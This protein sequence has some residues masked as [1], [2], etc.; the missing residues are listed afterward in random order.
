MIDM[1]MFGAAPTEQRT[2]GAVKV[3]GVDIPG[4][5]Y[6]VKYADEIKEQE[7]RDLERRGVSLGTHVAFDQSAKD[8]IQAR[9]SAGDASATIYAPFMNRDVIPANLYDDIV[10]SEQAAR[11]PQ[12]P[13]AHVTDPVTGQIWGQDPKTGRF[14]VDLGRTNVK[15]PEAAAARKEE[16]EL[17]KQENRLRAEFNRETKKVRDGLNDLERFTSPAEKQIKAGKTPTASDQYA[18]VYAYNKALDPASVVRESEFRNSKSIGAGIHERAWL[19]LQ[20]LK[21]GAQLTQHQVT[22]MLDTIGRARQS[23]HEALAE[24]TQRYRDTA[25]GYGVDPDKVTVL[26]RGS[27]AEEKAKNDAKVKGAT[28]KVDPKDPLGLRP[29]R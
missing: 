6:D 21:N 7:N 1:Q 28:V 15:D 8:K 18:L 2:V 19:Y 5:T 24:M 20:N 22:E 11:T 4:Y 29:K 12:I 17:L 10:R 14:D 25:G 9:I 26:G 16:A 13:K 23:S 3:G 27:E